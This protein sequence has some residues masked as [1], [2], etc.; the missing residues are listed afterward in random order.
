MILTCPNCSMRYSASASAIGVSGRKVRCAS[1]GHSW[2]VDAQGKTLEAQVHAEPAPQAEP[3]PLVEATQ[4]SEP[5]V[6]PETPAEESR[7]AK[8]EVAKALRARREAERQQKA[9][10]RSMGIWAVIAASLVIVLALAVVF[11]VNVVRLWPNTGSAFAAVGLPVNRFGLEVH[12]LS[13]ARQI[14][15]GSTVLA[16]SGNVV[17]I[18]SRTQNVPALQ[19]RL[20]DA[21][22]G[23]IAFSWDVQPTKPHLAAEEKLA[24][25]SE[26]RDPP[27]GNLEL[28]VAFSDAAP[29]NSAAKP[30]QDH[31]GDPHA[32]PRPNT[33]AD[34]AEPAHAQPAH[35]APVHDDHANG[36][37]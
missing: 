10:R 2:M 13:A 37:H 33:P 14:Q 12:D 29:A 21:K 8:P 17:N 16:I 7:Q 24:F 34:H 5:K 6:E 18:T 36:S 4:V 26:L 25:A 32:A 11:R 3:E 27:P 1:C 22:T 28:E 31:A 23:K 20:R 35:V 30:D 15:A 9:R 19:V